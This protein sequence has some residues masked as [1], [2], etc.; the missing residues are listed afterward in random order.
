MIRNASRRVFRKGKDEQIN[1]PRLGVCGVWGKRGLKF[2]IS[3]I[4]GNAEA[5]QIIL[6]SEAHPGIFCIG[7][8]FP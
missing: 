5:H 6:L 7:I 1:E 2:F 4:T 3:S 8:L